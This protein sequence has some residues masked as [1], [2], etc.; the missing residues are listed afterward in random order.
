MP[1][2]I[3]GATSGSTTIAAPDTGTDETIVLSTALASKA[4]YPS[5]GTDGDLLTKSGSS[6]AWATPSG[7]GL[8]LITTET[9]SAVS[10]V[11]I[12]GCFSAT[13][14]DYVIFGQL[15]YTNSS[16]LRVRFRVSGA[17]NTTSNYQQQRF[18]GAGTGTSISRSQNQDHGVVANAAAG[19]DAPLVGEILRPFATATA[20]F[21]GR[22]TQSNATGVA[23]EHR[24]TGFN[25]TT[26]F[27][28]MTLYPSAGTITGSFSIYG[29]AK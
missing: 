20:A 17:D 8:V 22:T 3:N 27:D 28:G 10:S 1:I 23:V 29:L 6:T 7:S 11:S 4:D 18:A 12:N 2:K 14:D 21:M 13:Y 19:V 16:D 15:A 26:S 25:A 9:V 24:Y 5:G